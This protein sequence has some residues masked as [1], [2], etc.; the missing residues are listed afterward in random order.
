[1][2]FRKAAEI[3]LAGARPSGDNAFKIELAKRIVV[4]ALALA[5]ARTP[6]RLPALPASPFSSPFRGRSLCLRPIPPS[7]ADPALWLEL[8]PAAHPPRRN[9]Q[10]YR[11]RNLRIGQP[12]RRHA[13]CGM[14]RQHDRAGTR[15]ASRRRSRQSASRCR[16]GA[17]PR[18]PAAAGRRPGCRSRGLSRSV[19]RRCRTTTC[20]TPTSRSRSSSPRRWRRRRKAPRSQSALRGR[21]GA[22]SDS[23]SD[24]FLPASRG[25]QLAPERRA[26]R[27]RGG[28]V[29]APL[30]ID[31]TYETPSQYHNA[32]EPHAIVAS[33]DG[34]RLTIDTP[35]QA[36]H[37]AAAAF[38]GFFGVPPE[39]VLIRTPFIGGG[40]GSK[41]ILAGAHILCVLAARMMGRPVKLV[42]TRAPDVRAGRPSRP[43]ATA[44]E[45][46][47]GDRRPA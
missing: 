2:A 29:D 34:D 16:Q 38:A 10:S 43:D 22:N 17:D 33:W 31:E 40:F 36:P 18:Q 35:N 39:N 6:E 12:S 23:T 47:L 19:W 27:C 42:L 25:G 21:A 44:T 14:R 28:I 11:T 45:A 30:R 3:A 41:A 24:H 13:V 8:G 15:G 20:A 1:M 46:R 26:R 7:F 4:R 32:M 37:M 9:P 5:S